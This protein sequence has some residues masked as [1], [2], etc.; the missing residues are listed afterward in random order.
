M[1]QF[2]VGDRIVGLPEASDVYTQTRA[3]THWIV[4]RIINDNIIEIV[5]DPLY[6]DYSGSTEFIINPKYFKLTEGESDMATHI[7]NA[8]QQ[9]RDKELDADTKILRK[10]EF[11]DS[12]GQLDQDG[13]TALMDLLY[14]Q[15]RATFA[16][17]LRDLEEAEA[18]PAADTSAT[19]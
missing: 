7:T 14:K 18:K 11:E 17:Q 15:H 16:Q 1:K 9:L 5:K 4:Q 6:D 8:V 2:K 10:Y 12:R 19:V 3:D 13:R